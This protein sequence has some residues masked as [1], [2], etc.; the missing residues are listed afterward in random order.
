MVSTLELIRTSCPYEQ[1]V[2]SLNEKSGVYHVFFE[3]EL[4]NGKRDPGTDGLLRD[5]LIE[6]Q[7]D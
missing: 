3:T 2:K 6:A 1:T 5:Q 4:M 7:I